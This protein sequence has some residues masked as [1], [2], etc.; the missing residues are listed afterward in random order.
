MHHRPDHIDHE[1]RT[2]HL[3]LLLLMH[4]TV[5]NWAPTT[6]GTRDRDPR[7][8]GDSNP[9]PTNTPPPTRRGR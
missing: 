5:T 9:S 8:T 6:S 2:T 1:W 4:G 3:Q 7:P